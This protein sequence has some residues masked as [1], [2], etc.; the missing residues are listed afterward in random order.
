MIFDS[1]PSHSGHDA[2]HIA[3]QMKAFSASYAKTSIRREKWL[4]QAPGSND[5]AM[6]CM[7]A[8]W[9]ISSGRSQAQVRDAFSRAFVDHVVPHVPQGQQSFHAI[10]LDRQ[11]RA[12]TCQ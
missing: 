2:I 1:L 8:A 10:A 7:K 12:G 4:M 11:L 9:M 3:E 5:C 6:Y